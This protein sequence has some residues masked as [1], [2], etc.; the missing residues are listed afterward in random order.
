MPKKFLNKKI[1]FTK[2]SAKNFTIAIIGEGRSG[3]SSL[4]KQVSLIKVIFLKFIEPL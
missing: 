3:K 1:G 4:I 2:S